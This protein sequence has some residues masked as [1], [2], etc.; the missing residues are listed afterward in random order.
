MELDLQI[1]WAPCAQLYSLAETPHP[2]TLIYST[3]ALLVSQ[4][5]RHLFVIPWEI[6]NPLYK[7]INMTE[8]SK[9]PKLKP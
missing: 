4:D 1:T 7:N 5:R 3:R 2:S 6:G 9:N 8:T